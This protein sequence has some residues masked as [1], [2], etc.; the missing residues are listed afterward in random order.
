MKNAG[1]QKRSRIRAVM[2]FSNFFLRSHSIFSAMIMTLPVSLMRKQRVEAGTRCL[3]G[4]TV[5]LCWPVSDDDGVQ[6]PPVASSP[7]SSSL[8]FRC[9]RPSRAV[10]PEEIF[11]EEELQGTYGLFVV[12]HKCARDGGRKGRGKGRWRKRRI[13]LTRGSQKVDVF[14]ETVSSRR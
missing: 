3:N 9:A 2:H 12:S 10:S 8:S 1:S 13:F 4:D 14:I 5:T 7:S 6:C 11:I